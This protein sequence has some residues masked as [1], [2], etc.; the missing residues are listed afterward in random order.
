MKADEQQIAAIC[1]QRGIRLLVLF[2]SRASGRQ[3]AG[4]DTDLAVLLDRSPSLAELAS[5]QEAMEGAIGEKRDI[6]FVVLNDL[7][8]TTLGREIVRGG[9]VLYDSDGE[10]WP[11]FACRAMKAYADFEPFRRLRSE[12]LQGRLPR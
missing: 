6:Q 9:R 10:Q 3:R 11:A 1:R 5:L 12:V 8:S 2:G 4:S 7:Q